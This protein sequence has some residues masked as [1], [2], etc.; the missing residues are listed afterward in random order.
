MKKL[1]LIV[2]VLLSVNM[3]YGQ[4]FREIAENFIDTHHKKGTIHVKSDYGV[5]AIKLFTKKSVVNR[6]MITTTIGSRLAEKIENNK[7]YYF[8]KLGSTFVDYWFS[9]DY[10]YVNGMKFKNEKPKD[11]IYYE[12]HKDIEHHKNTTIINKQK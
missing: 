12:K 4:S 3:F 11:D 8:R 6:V 10:I 5:I 1:I 2:I 9:S 7:D